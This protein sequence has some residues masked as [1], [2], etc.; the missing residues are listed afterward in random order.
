DRELFFRNFMA[1]LETGIAKL[2]WV[3]PE[4]VLTIPITQK[5]LVIG[6]GIAGMTAALAV[7][8]HGFEVDLVESAEDLGGNLSWLA[9]TLDGHSPKELLEETVTSVNKHP[10]IRVHIKSRVVHCSGEVGNF[11]TTIE[12]SQD[13]V[14]AL[15]HAVTIFATGGTEAATSSYG[16]GT[17]PAILTQKELELKLSNH[18]LDPMQLSSVV[19]IQCV[20]SR[21]EP[22]NYCSR[23]CCAGALKHALR[24]KSENPELRIYILYRDMMSYGFYETYYTQARK[25]NVMFIQYHVAEKPQVEAGQKGVKIMTRDPLIG[26]AIELEADLLVLATGVVPALSPDLAEAYG[27]TVDTD[28]FFQEAE[29]KWR[30]VDSLKEGVFA[31]GLTHSPRNIAETIATAEATAQRALRI[32]SRERLPAGRVVAKVRHSICSLCERCI[33]VCPYQAR[34]IDYENE[35][36]RVNPA[37]CQGCGSCAA[38]CPSGA[39]VLEG[40]LERQ[41]LEVID[42]VMG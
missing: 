22:R 28:G 2:K 38:T 34:T 11:H 25:A 1:T 20:D 19:M 18:T 3:D 30:P 37:M 21:E 33:D 8:D 17:S 7:A 31:C 15:K 29:S 42:A 10:K 40:F 26:R 5:A 39:S 23:L 16:Y 4:P 9:Q 41:M 14:H 6:G 13:E 36:V 12:D 35:K 27:A 24:L 32:L